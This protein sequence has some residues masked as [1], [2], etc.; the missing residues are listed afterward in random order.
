MGSP[1]IVWDEKA[2]LAFEAGSRA[3]A[4]RQSNA[5]TVWRV[6]VR[7]ARAVMRAYTTG[8]FI[9]SRFLPAHKRD[10]VEVIYAAVRYPDEVVDSFAL[11]AEE[12]MQRLNVWGEAYETSL[13]CG[14][15]LQAIRQG[16]PCVLAAFAE[17][18]RRAGIPPE[19][20]RAF[21][22]AM[23][24]D[25]CPRP[26][27]TLDDLI[28]SYIYGSAIVVGYFLAHVYGASSP[29]DFQRA[30]VSS[31][32]LGIGLQLTNFLRD[33]AEDQHRGRIYLPMDLLRGA[34]IEKMEADR[35]DQRE[36]LGRVVKRVA[37]IAR[38]YYG[39]A[40]QNLDAFAVDSRVAIKACIDVY[41]ALNTRILNSTRGI[42]HRESVPLR[43]KLRPL[44]ACKYWKIP[45]A[46]LTP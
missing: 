46:Y 12:R 3:L 23:R 14:S 5:Q 16:A 1:E 6:L 43:D 25:V 37:V 7:R 11:S 24:L 32:D 33:V 10:Q 22:D 31:R 45:L 28:D 18:V 15:V 34:G 36:A 29:Q 30:L 9:V 41:G 4:L 44:P 21:L 26:F 17:V 27:Q 19:H 20:Y 2:W 8:F 35:P 39:R 40:E 42:D 38:E 13:A